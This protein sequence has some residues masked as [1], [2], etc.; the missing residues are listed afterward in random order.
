MFSYE[1]NT[2]LQRVNLWA[3]RRVLFTCRQPV[4]TGARERFYRCVYKRRGFCREDSKTPQHKLDIINV[5]FN[6]TVSS[7]NHHVFLQSRIRPSRTCSLQLLPGFFGCRGQEGRASKWQVYRHFWQAN[8]ATGLRV[9][10]VWLC[11]LSRHG[12]WLPAAPWPLSLL[13][14]DLHWCGQYSLP[15][16]PE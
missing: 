7:T 1:K 15:P 2:K 16:L 3:T 11:I 12:R 9:W 13:F 10:L 4:N 5:S 8:R 6:F 14:A